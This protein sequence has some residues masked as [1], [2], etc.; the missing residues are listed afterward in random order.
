[1]W[2][3]NRGPDP[4]S[5]YDAFRKNVLSNLKAKVRSSY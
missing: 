5:E 1:M 4:I 2:S 3:E